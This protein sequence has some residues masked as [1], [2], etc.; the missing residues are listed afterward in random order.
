MSVRWPAGV[1]LR[2]LQGPWPGGLRTERDRA[3]FRSGLGA[4]VELLGRELKHLGAAGAGPAPAVLQMALAERDFRNDGLP[5]AHARPEHPGVILSVESR[6]GPLSY[7]CD[8]YR[9]WTDNLRAIALS[10]EALRRVDRYGVTR[11]AEQ[12]RGWAALPSG[13]DR[14]SVG[15]SRTAAAHALLELSGWPDG[16]TLNGVLSDGPARV[17]AVRRARA[18]CHPDK[19]EGGTGLWSRLEAVLAALTAPRG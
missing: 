19:H 14:A 4:T 2:P 9:D 16:V 1:V 7:P 18:L 5:R 8:R 6:H 11:N 13:Q 12:Y 10:L 17:R 3:P 15:L